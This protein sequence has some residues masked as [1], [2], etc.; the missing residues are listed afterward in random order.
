[1]HLPGL[2][3]SV[4]FA[5]QTITPVSRWPWKHSQGSKAGPDPELG[6]FRERFPLGIVIT[7]AFQTWRFGD[8]SETSIGLDDQVWP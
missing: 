6:E 4:S 3:E 7:R 2:S 8:S 5:P 1:M